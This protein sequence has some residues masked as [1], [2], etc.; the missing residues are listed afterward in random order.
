MAILTIAWLASP[1]PS[2]AQA[3]LSEFGSYPWTTP[4]PVVA[5]YV[6]A[7]NGNLHI[8]IP[9]DNLAERGHVP[10]VAKLVYDSHIWQQVTVGST[11]SWQPTN[12]SGIGGG[13]RLIASAGTGI[14]INYTEFE[15]GECVTVINHQVEYTPYYGFKN[16]S[17]TTPDGHNIPFGTVE[18]T[19]Y[20]DICGSGGGGTSNGISTDTSGYHL[21]VTNW[22][23]AVVYAPDGT[24]VY[25]Q[26]KDT[27]GNYY[28][29]D[30]NG[31]AVDP[32]GRT[33]IET[34]TNGNE[35]T[36]EVLNSQGGRFNYSVVTETIPVNTA[37]DESG[38]TEFSGNITVVSAI[39]LPDGTSYEF[40]YDQGATGPHFG[41]MAAMYVP[42]GG[43]YEYGY[44]NFIDAYGNYTHW[45]N[46]Y[47]LSTGGSWS[48]TPLVTSGCPTSCTQ[49]LT[50]TG[51]SGEHT[52]YGFSLNSAGAW[53]TSASYYDT[54]A[55]GGG[56]LQS[57]STAYN[58]SNLPYVVPQ[59]STL[60]LPI[61][62]GNLNKQSRFTFDSSNF[63]NVTEVDQTN[64][65]SNSAGWYRTQMNTYLSNSDNNMVNKKETIQIC[66]T[67]NCPT[68]SLLTET[69]ITYDG[70]TT[71]SITGIVNHD[72]TNFGT[73]YNARGNPTTMTNGLP[74]AQATAT[75]AYDMTGQVLSSKDNI[76]N[77]TSFSYTDSYYSDTS[78]GP[79][80]ISLSFKT[81]GFVTQTTLASGWAITA[82]YYYGFGQLAEKTDQNNITSTLNYLDYFGRL[83]QSETPINSTQNSWRVFAYSPLERGNDT[84]LGIT[85]TSPS[86][87]CTYCRHDQVNVDMYGRPSNQILVNDPEGA[88]TT[89]VTFN[90]DGQVASAT[91][92]E[93]S[94]S[95]GTDN[96]DS[97]VYD[98]LGRVTKVTHS[99]GSSAYTYYGAAVS[100]S[101]IS[102]QLCATTTYGYAYPRLFVDEA[103]K[104]RQIWSDGFGRTIEAD[105]QDNNGNLTVNTCYSYDQLGDL[106]GVTQGTQTRTYTYDALSRI[107]TSTTPE[108]GE[109]YYGY[110]NTSQQPCSG[111][112]NLLC[113]RT[114]ARRIIATY[115]YDNLNRLTSISY[116]PANTPSVTYTYDGQTNE[117]GFR[118]GMSD[119]LGNNVTWTYN[120]VGWVISEQRTIAGQTKTTSYTYNEDGSIA[121]ITYPSLRTITYTTSNAQRPLTAKDVANSIQYAVTASYAPPGE[122]NSVIYG[123]ATG[124][125]GIQQA[126]TYNSRSE[127]ITNAASLSSTDY[128]QNLSFTY[129]LPGNDGTITTV[130]NGVNSTLSETFTY[131]PLNR[132][133]SGN[134]S[135][136][137]AS[138]C[139][140]EG[141]GPSGNP[142]AGPPDDIHGNLT[143]IN[144][145]TQY[146]ACSNDSLAVTAS[147][148]TNQ[149]NTT[150]YQYDA[151]GNMTQEGTSPGNTY[152]YDAES[153]LTSAVGSTTG[154]VTY[155]YVYDGNGLRVEKFQ[156]SSGTCASPVGVT[157]DLLYWRAISGQT[158]TETDGSG[159]VKDEY[160][161]FGGQRIA[162][163]DS[164]GNVNYFYSDQ[165]GSITVMT[166]GSG[167]P[168]YQSTFTPYGKE[169]AIQTGCSTQYKF[170]GY[171]RDAE[172]GLDYAFA[173]YYNSRLGRFMSA[174]PAGGAPEDPQSLN[175][176]AYVGNGGPNFFDPVGME[177][178]VAPP[179]NSLPTTCDG[180]GYLT[181][182]NA[183]DVADVSMA[184][185]DYGSIYVDV[186]YIENIDGGYYESSGST[187]TAWVQN[188][189]TL[190][191][192]IGFSSNSNLWDISLGDSLN[193][194]DLQGGDIAAGG[195]IAGA[196]A[197]MST[198]RTRSAQEQVNDC[199]GEIYGTG[200]G[201]GVQALSPLQMIP[202][203]GQDPLFSMGETAAGVSTKYAAI[204]E[205]AGTAGVPLSTLSGNSWTLA[206]PAE[207]LAGAAA[208][209]TLEA[210]PYAWGAAAIAD[211]MIHAQ[212]Q[213]ESIGNYNWAQ[214][215]DAI[216]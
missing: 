133:L 112:P 201:K 190:Q 125:N 12:V 103:G 188:P 50:K 105:E 51:P 42:S 38:I 157:V 116:S 124:F 170:T 160:M 93:R 181:N 120:N 33:P 99:D 15:E 43:I 154:G 189:N 178:C 60:T 66:S 184:W 162:R 164:N 214:G 196:A 207:Q 176:Y 10:Y 29:S 14:G 68:G 172:T 82:G 198:S 70:A 27:N 57:V 123:P 77:M 17:Y 6:D 28:S 76:G 175:R 69:Q 132:I 134:T 130:S 54:T 58:F 55:N 186:V 166:D 182:T 65:Y 195:I 2:I 137:S 36:Y 117:K 108:S 128:V 171:E 205:I 193:L 161:F 44:Q 7:A 22:D 114:D 101:G 80:P 146:S 30:G 21:Y 122:L 158:I 202:G 206:G 19:E 106:T 26:V 159:N 140:G 63:G 173:R 109:V 81:N 89:T 104:K 110:L 174:D 208:R 53:N 215:F 144:G 56:I 142:P 129:N 83:T 126:Y 95:S 209:G 149:I 197:R 118:T 131:D 25:P 177:K 64:F 32:V 100:S 35:I 88:D 59:S 37:F 210:A 72:D 145:L 1:Q 150:G 151:S 40:E 139:W 5:G 163:R 169:E 168:C 48:F 45:L 4:I 194:G 203:F 192:A 91:T 96:T 16:W 84:Y 135:S 52:V 115:A 74:T 9:I 180:G 213:N 113:F 49:Q 204:N 191:W 148:T 46:S 24:Q 13:W 98:G 111:N 61:P 75:L 86:T 212:C 138:G 3:Y 147:A 67:P 155:C 31:N 102:T 167:N 92:P 85:D 185:S 47:S 165:I 216:P 200:L 143:E 62:G 183:N 211:L 107:A 152:T 11:T 90:N 23:Q 87:T 94:T 8:E 199:L 179:G 153:R 121:S 127:T 71:S 18:T 34:Q 79:S 156:I 78:S 73:S 20:G 187:Q 41:V 141:Y 39:N 97:Y 136:T 119:S